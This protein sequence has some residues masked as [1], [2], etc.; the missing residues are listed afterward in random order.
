VDL[1]SPDIYQKKDIFAEM[2][3]ICERMVNQ[4]TMVATN[5]TRSIE[6]GQVSD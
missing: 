4:N 6:N 5:S 1:S 3:Q 2:P